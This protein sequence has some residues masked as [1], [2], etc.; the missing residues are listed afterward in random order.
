[1]V[2]FIGMELKTAIP[3][4]NDFDSFLQRCIIRNASSTLKPETALRPSAFTIA[5]NS[6]FRVSP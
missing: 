4:A 2:P 5:T 6:W 3:I 1:M